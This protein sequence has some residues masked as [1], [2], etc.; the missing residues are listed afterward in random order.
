MDIVSI[1]QLSLLLLS[2]F[3]I[4]FAVLMGLKR[5]FKKSL[6]RFIWLFATFIILLIVSS[7]ITGAL[8]TID[9][10]FLNITVNDV[11]V[12]NLTEMG[13]VLTQSLNLQD[14]A[15]AGQLIAAIPLM[16]INTI[17]FVLLLNLKV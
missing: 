17:L 12:S 11:P 2:V 15:V 7:L 1:I 3:I 9:L 8:A 10:T 6:F 16:L 5:G 4:G 13:E 14:A